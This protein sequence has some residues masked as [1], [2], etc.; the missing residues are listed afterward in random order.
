MGLEPAQELHLDDPL[1][2]ILHD[3][4]CEGFCGHAEG[5]EGHILHDLSDEF[6]GRMAMAAREWAE[7][8]L[9]DELPPSTVAALG[10]HMF[11]DCSV[12][13]V[14]VDDPEVIY[15]CGTV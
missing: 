3:E 5:D 10:S 11:A 2:E 4:L 7:A 15:W 13:G 8:R 14:A 12:C 9:R 6:W 1:A